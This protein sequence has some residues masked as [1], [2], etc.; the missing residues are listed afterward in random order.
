MTPGTPPDVAPLAAVADLRRRVAAQ[1]AA[2][3][4]GIQTSARASDLTDAVVVAVWNGIAAEVPAPGGFFD[5]DVALVAHGGYG[6]REM[7]P[8]SDVDL[9][10]LPAA[11]PQGPVAE[12]ARRLLQALFDAGLQ[13]GQSV[14]T[15]G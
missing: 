10:I 2:G 15:V 5:R 13:V 3:G 1:H 9:M 4:P 6:R 12:A 14:R 11:D 8:F 7:A